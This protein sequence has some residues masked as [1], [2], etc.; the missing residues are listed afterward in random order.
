[1][2]IQGQVLVRFYRIGE[3]TAF[4]RHRG[5]VLTDKEEKQLL[6]N[7]EI[8]QLTLGRTSKRLPSQCYHGEGN[9]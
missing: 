2:V 7:W 3:E 8:K 4:E 1:M 9:G 5:R 6:F